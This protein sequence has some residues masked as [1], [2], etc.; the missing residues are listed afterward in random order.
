MRNFIIFFDHSEGK[1][2]GK[3]LPYW[4][5]KSYGCLLTHWLPKTG[6]LFGIYLFSIFCLV[7]RISIKFETFSKKIKMI[8]IV[9][10]F[11]PFSRK[12][13]FRTLFD[14]QRVSG[15]KTLVKSAWKHLY[16]TFLSLWGEII[17]K[18]SP[19]FKLEILTAFVNT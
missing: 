17:R 11:K 6:M 18:I 1:W 5:L 8:V 19:F 7:Y 15:C 3:Y 14:S 10:L 16:H 12:R 2:L 13:C 4:T 9:N